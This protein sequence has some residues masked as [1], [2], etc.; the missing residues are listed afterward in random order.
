MITKLVGAVI[1][2]H[3]PVMLM[4]D[5]A[6]RIGIRIASEVGEYRHWSFGLGNCFI[7]MLAEDN[8]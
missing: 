7:R 4:V 8:K 3:G 5:K 2:K 6:G 1:A